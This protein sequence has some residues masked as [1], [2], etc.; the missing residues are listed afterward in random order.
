MQPQVRDSILGPK[1]LQRVEGG[2]L[3]ALALLLYGKSGD[4]SF[5][6]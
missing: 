5:E 4:G 2:V 3:L 6:F 1:V